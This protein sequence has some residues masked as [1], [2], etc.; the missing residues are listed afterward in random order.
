M[1]RTESEQ[2]VFSVEARIA[3]MEKQMAR[4]SRV[5]DT[6]MT[7]IERRGKTMTGRLEKTMAASASRV[8]GLMKNFGVGFLGGLTAGGVAGVVGQ[9]GSVASGIAQIGDE[10]RRAGVSATAF[11]EWKFVAQQN[12]I[13]IDQM[14]DGLKELN[15]RADEFVQTGKGSAAEA[16]ARL[17]YSAA[18]LKTKLQDPSALLLEIIDRLGKFDK[19]AQIRISDE[20]FGGSAGERFVELI[21]QGTDGIKATIQQAH[22]LNAVLDDDVIASAAELDRKFNAVATT[23]GSTLKSAIVSA[24]ESLTD[25]INAFKGFEFERTAKLDQRMASLGKERLD[26]ERQIL[27]LKDKQRRG[28]SVGDGIFGTSFG[29]STALEAMADYQRRL[30]AIAAE[31]Q[32]IGKIIDERRVAK[33]PASTWTPPPPPPGG[34][35]GGGGGGRDKAAAQAEREADAVRRLIGELQ[36]ELSLVGA[37]DTQK[38]ISATLRR[39]NV[40]AA[41]AEGQQIAALITEIERESDALE[42][43]K[44]AQ[45]ARTQAI[46]NMFDMGA[47]ALGSIVDGSVKAEDAVKKLAVQLAIAA[48]QAALLGT[49]PLAGLGGGG[50]CFGGKVFTLNIRRSS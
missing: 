10:A 13:G 36:E 33:P 32:M 1:A 30:E 5:T 50:G 8:S 17:G 2:L 18:D 27:E 44:Q 34:F 9:L 6:T 4:A 25:F 41:S 38:Q 19:A 20:L 48:A 42:K 12:R 23:V 15:L 39:A 24:A 21:D 47:D 37:S 35:G 26:V 3:A 29:E 28:E 31:E 16:F 49:G 22:N 40:D 14:T 45:E 7:G 43:N 11:Q 46:S